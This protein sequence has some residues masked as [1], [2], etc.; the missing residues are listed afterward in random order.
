MMRA[1]GSAV[2]LLLSAAGCGGVAPDPAAMADDLPT[3]RAFPPERIAEL[4]ARTDAALAALI[5]GDFERAEELAEAVL[6]VDPRRARARA[7]LA[8]CLMQ[9]AIAESPPTL[10]PWR[11]AEGE[12]R[13]AS[14]LAP[15]DPVVA[16]LHAAFL[17]ADGH[18]S[19][20]AE[21][22][23]AGVAANPNDQALLE[24]AARLRFDLGDERAAIPLLERFLALAPQNADAVWRLA[25]A[26][27][28]VAPAEIEHDLRVARRDAAVAAFDRYLKLA[29]DDP[30][31]PLAAATARF[32]RLQETDEP[33]AELVAAILDL[34]DRA[35]QLLPASP[36]PHFGRGAVLDVAGRADAARTAYRAALA[37]DQGHVPSLLNLAA[38]LAAAGDRAAAIPL[39]RRAL[40][41]GVTDDERTRIQSFLDP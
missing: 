39:L 20:A 35:A 2:V 23:E 4:G 14:L 10:A 41:L 5:A 9:E 38:N 6:A 18:L 8:H 34:Y 27:A 36:A 28:R 33:D 13:R 32:A 17:A 7:V 37:L 31:G 15:G 12:L 26:H 29:P 21:R 19:A 16:R 1:S 24:L 3:A 25:Q 30:E 22:A 11:R 40:I